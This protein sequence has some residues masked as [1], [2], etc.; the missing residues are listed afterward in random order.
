MSSTAS[1]FSILA[2]MGTTRPNFFISARQR[3]TS[4]AAR[5]KESATQ[6]TPWERPKARSR[7]SFSESACARS[8]TPGRLMPLCSA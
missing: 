8:V 3:S 4:S 7:L 1:G 2:M 5:T 6:S